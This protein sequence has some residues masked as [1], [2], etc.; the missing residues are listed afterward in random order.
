[1]NTSLDSSWNSASC[2]TDM[3]S[4]SNYCGHAVKNHCK[5][6]YPKDKKPKYMMVC[7]PPGPPGP[8]GPCGPC[9][10]HGHQGPPGPPG[11]QGQQGLQGQQGQQGFQGAMG[12]QGFQGPQ[13]PH[14]Q[15]GHTGNIGNTG[16]TGHT[17]TT[18][19]GVGTSS[20]TLTGYASGTTRV[21]LIPSLTNFPGLSGPV[22]GTSNATVTI[23][24]QL[25]IQLVNVNTPQLATFP[26][27]LNGIEIAIIRV[28]FV[29][30]REPTGTSPLIT[31]YFLVESSPTIPII[32]NQN[33]TNNITVYMEL[34]TTALAVL[35]PPRENFIHVVVNYNR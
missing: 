21:Q 29:Q 12:Q 6:A 13:G 22:T 28:P 19:H 33:I 2:I 27:Y 8:C 4:S 5:K 15:T 23:S 24:I 7:G 18:G 30:Y 26:V 31:Y 32:L 14:G 20:A 11:P 25:E 10:N 34:S 3:S 1:M 17:G 16:H 35:T 9:G